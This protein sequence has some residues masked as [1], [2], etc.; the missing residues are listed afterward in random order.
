MTEQATA[1]A[2]ASLN[3]STPAAPPGVEECVEC[4]TNGERFMGGAGLLVGVI[5]AAI[6]I[7]LISGGALSR[8]VTGILARPAT[9]T[10]DTGGDGQA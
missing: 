8:A 3:G 5:I 2:A 6:G 1:A 4:A 7:D 9:T 10:E